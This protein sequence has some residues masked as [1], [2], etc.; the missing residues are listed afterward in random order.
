MAQQAFDKIYAGDSLSIRLKI[1]TAI[2]CQP[3]ADYN[4][5]SA[6]SFILAVGDP[7][8]GVTYFSKTYLKA[9]VIDGAPELGEVVLAITGTDTAKVPPG[10]R[11]M[12]VWLVDTLARQY[13]IFEQTFEQRARLSAI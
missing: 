3:T 10:F 7:L 11:T 1:D 13:T 4:L 6:A 9:D 2:N 8:D 12:Q 5:D